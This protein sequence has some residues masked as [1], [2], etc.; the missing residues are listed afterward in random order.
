MSPR[1]MIVRLAQSP[2]FLQPMLPHPDDPYPNT[3][4]PPLP[5]PSSVGLEGKEGAYILREDQRP[6]SP[7]Q[8][9]PSEPPPPPHHTL[10]GGYTRTE[11]RGRHLLFTTQLD[12]PLQRGISAKR[13]I[14]AQAR[15][16]VAA[17]AAAAVAAYLAAPAQEE[18]FL[19][20]R[21]AAAVAAASILTM[22]MDPKGQSCWI[23][24][25]WA[26]RSP[27]IGRRRR[28]LRS[29]RVASIPRISRCSKQTTGRSR[30]R[31]ASSR[32]FR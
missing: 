6:P 20:A 23:T 1:S 13:L 19:R 27:R 9:R 32:T 17:G 16:P 31:G 22:A 18:N 24:R 2:I 21:L 10:A 28:R 5:N 12:L 4:P 7:T 11:R 8:Q 30:G 14:S 26:R 15:A 3:P 29:R 25:R